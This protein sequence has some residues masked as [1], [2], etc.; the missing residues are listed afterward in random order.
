MES[1]DLIQFRAGYDII[2]KEIFNVNLY[3]QYMNLICEEIAKNNIRGVNGLIRYLDL[4][5][6]FPDNEQM[7][8]MALSH[9]SLEMFAMIYYICLLWNNEDDNCLYLKTFKIKNIPI[10]VRDY[11]LKMNFLTNI[12]K[13]HGKFHIG[14]SNI[15]QQ[16][17]T[18]N[19]DID[20][21]YD[22]QREA[23]EKCINEALK[24]YNINM[25]EINRQF[26]ES[27]HHRYNELSP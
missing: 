9:G 14:M 11:E 7:F 23:F 17:L 15:A 2:K 20:V 1:I 25:K 5:G 4:I 26:Y 16:S 21:L 8:N 10:D 13:Y 3:L 24:T 12:Y 27:E 22:N 18:E 19:D 6:Y